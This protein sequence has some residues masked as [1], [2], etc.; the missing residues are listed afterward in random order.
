VH[1]SD[2]F[3]YIRPHA[4]MLPRKGKHC[5]HALVDYLRMPQRAVASLHVVNASWHCRLLS[6]A[7]VC[8]A[9]VYYKCASS[10]DRHSTEEF[11]VALNA[12]AFTPFEVHRGS[13]ATSGPVSS[14]HNFIM[15]G[16]VSVRHKKRVAPSKGGTT[17]F[18]C[19]LL[20]PVTSYH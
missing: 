17:A 8:L 18:S 5:I 12:V 10:C 1:S 11:C 14:T 4:D 16:S 3:Y 9:Q 13:T 7:I 15:F 19:V 20:M 6:H 2:H